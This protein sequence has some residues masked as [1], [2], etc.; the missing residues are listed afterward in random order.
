MKRKDFKMNRNRIVSS[1]LAG[2][3][4]LSSLSAAVF[5]Q[6]FSEPIADDVIPELAG[7]QIPGLN[8][9]SHE[10]GFGIA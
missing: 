9:V 4:A 5:A 6:D 10:E 2:T 1:L 8:V 7:G 3:L